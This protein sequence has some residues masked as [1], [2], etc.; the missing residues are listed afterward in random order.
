MYNLLIRK[1]T[2]TREKEKTGPPA[3]WANVRE[4]KREH[5]PMVPTSCRHTK[6]R[7][8]R[9]GEENSRPHE[10]ENTRKG[11][12]TTS[13]L[14]FPSKVQK[15]GEGGKIQPRQRNGKKEKEKRN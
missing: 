15:K 2:R 5:R 13:R 9:E 14:V 3:R 8:K 10:Q 7:G 4:K 6:E 11:R 1:I 12:K